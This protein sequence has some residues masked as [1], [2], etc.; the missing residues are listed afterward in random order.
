MSTLNLSDGNLS[1]I[2]KEI[3]ALESE[4]VKLAKAIADIVK[5]EEELIKNGKKTIDTLKKNDDKVKALSKRFDDVNKKLKDFNKAIETAGKN[6]EG[7][8]SKL[9]KLSEEGKKL[10]TSVKDASAKV[11]ELSKFLKELT[12]NHTKNK[13]AVTDNAKAYDALAKKVDAANKK[14][15]ENQE[16]T[17]QTEGKSKPEGAK[18]KK[19]AKADDE[20]VADAGKQDDLESK[21]LDKDL[22]T[23]S[24]TQEKLSEK[25]K[26]S[27]K[28]LKEQAKAEAGSS[29]TT[30]DLKKSAEGLGESVTESAEKTKES[31]DGINFFDEA[32]KAVDKTFNDLEKSNTDFASAVSDVTTGF[33]MMQSGFDVVKTGFTGI[34]S[35]IKSSGLWLLQLV[36]EKVYEYF[37]KNKEGIKQFQG[38]LAVVQK[39]IA[40][41]K[42]T[43]NSIKAVI[44]D[45]VMHPVD[46]AKKVWGTLS[47]FI[48]D[49]FSIFSTIGNTIGNAFKHPGE[50]VKKIW[51]VIID[52]LVSRFKGIKVLLEGLFHM[53]FKKMADG[54][55]QIGTGVTNITDKTAKAVQTFKKGVNE[56]Y[57][58]AGKL[59]TKVVDGAQKTYQEGH[60]RP[61][62][63]GAK[64]PAGKGTKTPPTKSTR[65]AGSKKPGGDTVVNS[66][67]TVDIIGQDSQEILNNYNKNIEATNTYF[68]S[69]KKQH[70]SSSQEI[71]KIEIAHQTSLK[72]I[73]EK[74]QNEDKIKLEQYNHELAQIAIDNTIDA[75]QK[76]ILQLQE[77]KRQKLT[78]MDEE[79]NAINAKITFQNLLLIELKKKGNVAE[80]AA[81][82]ESLKLQQQILQKA[83]D[84]KLAYIEQQD[85]KEKAIREGK[86]PEA[87]TEKKPDDKLITANQKPDE[88][89]AIAKL[90]DQ[91]KNWAEEKRLAVQAARD[92]GQSVFDVEA[93]F[94]A[95]KVNLEAQ[96]I[97][98]KMHKA[99]GF[100]NAVLQNTKKE[101]GIYKAAFIAKKATS[102]SDTIVT[103]SEA[104]MKSFGA[105]S[106]IPFIGQA[107][108]IAQAAFM[109]AQGATSIANIVK[110]KP[111]MA[112]GG[113]FISDGRGAVL[114]GY[115]RTDNT[116]AY[117][118]SGEAVV[119]SEAMRNPWAR[120]LV[121][122]IN[123]A[124][125]GR[126]F[127]VPNAGRGYAIG[128]I[129]T[130]GGNANRYYS[131]PVND[132]K[133]LAN[134]LAYQMINN[135]PP[136]YVDVKD[137]NN[138]QN[139]LAQTV[140]R[141]NL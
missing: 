26:S 3:T 86:D 12:I 110:Q 109:A 138:Q 2:T 128:G 132:Q 133:D 94:A 68:A 95:M 51:N 23:L 82:E 116:N 114:P 6:A 31:A 97:N 44:I 111:G 14:L 62:K 17:S 140:D 30:D 90:K 91:Q 4:A 119:V 39:A 48:K 24:S 123:V 40:F 50:A 9:S 76:A 47:A 59:V 127:S 93:K 99:D 41:V 45:A 1:E 15:K 22:N 89:P 112:R 19:S 43:L 66:S 20:D 129:F 98:A 56:L 121:S 74:F 105:Y 67:L 106:G 11:K 52:N 49:K 103:T 70:K 108:G 100:I 104:V 75:Q 122:A 29:K 58:D 35:A 118:R 25:T 124:H 73:T 7:S 37:T 125:G 53:D 83:G 5:E 130:D 88:D 64:P 126:D 80:I 115:S 21:E 120:N 79:Q 63:L 10:S 139:I 87:P 54:V 33:N 113:Q 96:I 81:L 135:F 77:D 60:D 69:L 16:L 65:R 134:T 84:V 61:P 46:T 78:Q 137:V 27:T 101:S 18:K 32:G 13:K 55:V 117:L 102:I 34:G 85:K 136:I 131:Q 36:L 92:K 71:Q 57:D 141:V 28:S 42:D 38:G 107:L 8:D 72:Q